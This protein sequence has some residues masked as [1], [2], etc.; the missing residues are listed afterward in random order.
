MTV[1]AVLTV[2]EST[3]CWSY[4]I[5]FQETTVTVLTVLAVSAVSVMT[6]KRA[7]YGFGE[8]AFKHRTQ[9]VF[10]GSLSSGERI[11][12][13]PF[14][15]SFVCQNELAEF[16][17]ELTEFA[18]KLSEVQWVLFSETQPPFL[19]ILIFL[20]F[21][22]IHWVVTHR[23]CQ[24][25]QTS[26]KCLIRLNFWDTLWEQ[27]GLSDQS[28]LIDATLRR[29]PLKNLCKKNLHLRDQKINR[30]NVYED[31]MV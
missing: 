3:F 10:W 8:Y 9:W 22:T 14:S 5:Q 12:W 13:V 28:A 25:A 11:Q 24:K 18:P 19:V 6:R 1:L 27:F 2:L 15:L 29:K 16:F 31:V 7:E 4:K 26:E 21:K 30:G 17:A 23:A 20:A